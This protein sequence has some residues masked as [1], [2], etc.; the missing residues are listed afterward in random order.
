VFVEAHASDINITMQPHER[1]LF[2]WRWR[3]KEDNE[4]E[5]ETMM[6]DTMMA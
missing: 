5:E 3:E 1:V 4:E 2:Q 6:F